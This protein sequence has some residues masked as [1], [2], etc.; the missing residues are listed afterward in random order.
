M[1]IAA[2]RLRGRGGFSRKKQTSYGAF[3]VAT[4]RLTF[5]GDADGGFA[6]TDWV[7]RPLCDIPSG[8]CSF[9]GP[10]T[11]TRSA[12]PPP[13]PRDGTVPRGPGP[14]GHTMGTMGFMI[15]FQNSKTAGTYLSK[16]MSR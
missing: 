15:F 14:M 7:W 5:K 4:R 2:K 8:C 3:W 9:T 10:W 12:P 6:P 13:T 16:S 1:D 11:V